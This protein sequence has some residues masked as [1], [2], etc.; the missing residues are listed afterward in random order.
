[1]FQGGNKYSHRMSLHPSH[2]ET[3]TGGLWHLAQLPA[4][5]EPRSTPFARASSGDGNRPPM[6]GSSAS[7]PAWRARMARS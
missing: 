6:N 1:M 3:P 7:F 2:W 4:T 5:S